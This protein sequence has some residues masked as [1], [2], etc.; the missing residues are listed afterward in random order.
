MYEIW[1][2]LNILYELALSEWPWLLAL[3]VLWAVLLWRAVGSGRP[4]WR[5]AFPWALAIGATVAAVVGLGIPAW[6]RS[7]LAELKYW[8]DWANLL[9]MAAAWGLAALMVAWPLMAHL[10]KWPRIAAV[11]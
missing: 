5:A 11:R 1:L 7:S 9:A 3:V 6:S 2:V 10:Q 8:V 4:A